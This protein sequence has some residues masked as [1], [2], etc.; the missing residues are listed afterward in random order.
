V[1]SVN[2]TK[3]QN[4]DVDKII[5]VL[6]ALI[7]QP[8][9]EI[10]YGIKTSAIDWLVCLAPGA[11]LSLLIA[12]GADRFLFS[13]LKMG[14]LF[15]PSGGV[16]HLVYCVM[17]GLSGTYAWG[18][19]QTALHYR[20]MRRLTVVFQTAGLKNAIGKLPGFVFDKP[21]DD[22]TR[23]MRLTRANL[24]LSQ[25]QGAK[26]ALESAL[27]VYIDDIVENR[28]RGTIDI[29]YASLA[30]PK[31]VKIPD[32]KDIGRRK[33]L[34]GETRAKKIYFDFNETPHLLV[35]GQSGGGKSTFL[36]QLITTL[37][38][39]NPTF[40]FSLIDLKGGLEFQIFERLRRIETVPNVKTAL[41]I[42]ARLERELVRRMEVLKQA[43][44]KDITA[45]LS[46]TLDE[47]KGIEGQAFARTPVVP[48]IVVI[49]E[50]AELFMAG[51]RSK[52]ANA[53]SAKAHA[54][55]IAAQGRAV[56]IHLI[57]AT[58]RPDVRAVDGQ[59]KANLSGALAF[60][61]PNH[62]SSMT[63]LD[64]TRAAHLPKIPGRAVW[65]TGLEMVEIQTPY[66]TVDE[67]NAV[68]DPFR[69][70]EK[71]TGDE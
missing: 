34:I 20:V 56:G 24:T 69:K 31:E 30:M 45:Y 12:T 5:K 11:A 43:Q 26:D 18:I 58:Q 48:E 17:A 67:V 42:L 39:N 28:E 35:G 21:M 50:A 27:Q 6:K 63:I 32:F 46:K 70:P 41:D 9:I 14:W 29:T 8:V 22:V 60:Q 23:K 68:L 2:P 64:N 15:P 3:A 66:V 51:D 36:R 37:Y 59:I 25:F 61:M 1:S 52:A 65:K 38:L 33:F 71:E 57:I 7:G 4:I 16:S 44:C 55:K 62:A 10:H 19:W 53:Q 40:R 13:F 47:R 49:D 54:I